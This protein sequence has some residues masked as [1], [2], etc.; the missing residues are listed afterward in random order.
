MAEMLTVINEAGDDIPLLLAQLERMGVR[1]L[2][3]EHFRT[4]GNWQGLSVGWVT[5][6]WLT[7][8]LSQ[9]DHRLSYVQGWVAKHQETLGG[10]TGQAVRGL[11]FSDERLGDVLRIF[12]DD[13][14]WEGFEEAVNQ[15]LLG[16]YELD[17]E[18][19]R[20]DSTTASGYWKV[21]P[22]GLF[23][24]GPSKDQRPDLPQ[25][26]VQLSTLDPLGMPVVRQILAGDRAD[27]PLYIP[28][29]LQVRKGVGR[30]GLLYVGDCK[31][32]AVGTRAFI[33]QGGDFYLCPLGEVHVSREVLEGYLAPV[34]AKKRDL[35]PIYREKEDGEKEL[36]AVGY[37][38][39][40]V[41]TG[42]VDGKTIPWSERRLIV[43][44]LKR[45]E[46]G[47]KALRER[48]AKA[49]KELAR[50]NERRRGKKRLTEEGALCQAAEAILQRY[51]V[52]GLLRVSYTEVVWE[53]SVRRYRER[54]ATG[55]VER[56]WKVSAVI[57]ETA[58][59]EQVRWLGWRVYTTNQSAEHLPLGQGVLAYRGEYLV[60][61][62]F[63]RL[64]GH[65]LSLTA[66][67]L[68]R[69]DHVKG[70]LRLLSLGLR[71]LT[72][73]E[74]VVRQ[75][76][77]EEEA[78][79]AGLYAGNPKRATSRPT[80]EKLLEALEGITLTIWEEPERAR[81]HLTPLSALQQRILALLGFSEQI[82]R[83]LCA[84]SSQSP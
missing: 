26:K 11:D 36:I 59:E 64:K 58:V 33:H 8:I 80:T 47:E 24:L 9:A 53:R 46:A 5:E 15:R 31:R 67:Y 62:G 32:G 28:A 30:V 17:P 76:L 73:L 3:D 69:E 81:R 20:L 44:S 60:E 71:V 37:E 35:T 2:L 48:L 29:V 34:W 43:R 6:V 63:G 39:E 70:L 23:Q 1:S 4:H 14:V 78:Q 7:H 75:G 84:D 38:Q 27:D 54:P 49:Q 40:V 61:R 19:V 66:M 25:I 42:E 16:V 65:P 50:L 41:V 74:C 79:L 18:Q 77:A 72:L 68:Q 56:E 45:A 22:E 10:G 55:R 51:G 12:S 83:R 57:D 52:Q 21:T 82:Y 13:A